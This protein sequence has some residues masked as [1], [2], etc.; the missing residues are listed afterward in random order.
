MS[1]SGFNL[2]TLRYHNSDLTAIR[3]LIHK[4]PIQQSKLNRCFH[5]H[6]G[7][8]NSPLM[9]DEDLISKILS[10]NADGLD[11]FNKLIKNWNHW[12]WKMHL[13]A[14]TYRMSP[15]SRAYPRVKSCWLLTVGWLGTTA[16]CPASSF[17]RPNWKWWEFL[18]RDKAIMTFKNISKT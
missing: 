15:L 5:L 13:I 3:S 7:M 2:P 18:L 10:T 14:L 11:H 9:H 12:K 17:M 16:H 6:A 4:P 8:D 1:S